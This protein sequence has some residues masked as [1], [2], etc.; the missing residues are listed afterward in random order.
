MTQEALRPCTAQMNRHEK[1]GPAWMPRAIRSRQQDDGSILDEDAVQG[2]DHSHHTIRTAILR[3]ILVARS[4]HASADLG[5][6]ASCEAMAVQTTYDE[7]IRIHCKARTAMIVH[8]A[9]LAGGSRTGYKKARPA[10]SSYG[11]LSLKNLLLPRSFVIR[12]Q[13]SKPRMIRDLRFSSLV[14]VCDGL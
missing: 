13:A 9:G 8:G 1:N 6:R 14:R 4:Y 11:S 5:R 12:I 3:M 2:A 7:M 10:P